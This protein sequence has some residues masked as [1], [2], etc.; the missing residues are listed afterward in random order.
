MAHLKGTLLACLGAALVPGAA[1][2]LAL[3]DG[4]LG[5]STGIVAA[6][7]MFIAARPKQF[8]L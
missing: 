3:G 6:L 7:I 5:L 2:G 4:A 1:V 8:P